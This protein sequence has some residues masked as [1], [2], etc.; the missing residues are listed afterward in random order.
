MKIR[1]AIAGLFCFFFAVCILCK[2]VSAGAILKNDPI[3]I[4]LEKSSID[5]Q[6]KFLNDLF[7]EI[8]IKRVAATK[9]TPDQNDLE[10]VERILKTAIQPSEIRKMY[11]DGIKSVMPLSE[12]NEVISWYDSP[13]GQ[14]I[15]KINFQSFNIDEFKKREEF[16]TDIMN[17]QASPRRLALIQRYMKSAETVKNSIK[18]EYEL[19]I[20]KVGQQARITSAPL[21]PMLDKLKKDFE[22]NHEQIEKKAAQKSF[23]NNLFSFRNHSD[24]D[25][26]GCADFIDTHAGHTFNSISH[27]VEFQVT[28]RFL[29]H[30]EEAML[31][32]S[33]EA[34]ETW[35][36]DEYNFSYTAPNAGWVK[37][38]ATNI[39]PNAKL[40]L[41]KANPQIF[42][43]IIPEII[44]LDNDLTLDKFVDLSKGNIKSLA[45]KCLISDGGDYTLNTIKGFQ[46]DV[47]AIVGNYSLSYRF[48]NILN[49]GLAYQL[50]AWTQDQNKAQM[51]SLSEQIFKGFQIID[52]DKTFYSSDYEPF[53]SFS[54]PFF[55][56]S[57]SL[58][59]QGWTKWNDLAKYNPEAEVGGEKN[60]SMFMVVPAHIGSEKVGSEVIL[61]AFLNTLDIVSSDKNITNLKE[62]RDAS[63]SGY[64]LNYH[65][66]IN[67]VPKN[68]AIRI[69]IDREIAYMIAAWTNEKNTDINVLANKLNQSFIIHNTHTSD[70][71]PGNMSES[72]KKAQASFDSFLGSFYY[73]A[74]QYEKALT[75][76][77][78][79]TD[80]N[81]SEEAYLTA[82]LSCYSALGSFEQGL[83]FLDKHHSYHPD[84]LTILSWKAW[85]LK[86][87][88]QNEKSLDIYR[89]LFEK[90]YRSDSDFIEFVD[91]LGTM[92]R[93]DD[94][95]PAFTAYVRKDSSIDVHI[96]QASLLHDQGKYREAVNLLQLLQKDMPFQADISFALARSFNAMEE[97]KDVITVA[98]ALITR[99]LYLTDAYFLKG[100]AEFDL[101][102]YHK[103]KESF[104]NALKE[105]PEDSQIKNYIQH[106]S[107]IIGQGDNTPIKNTIQPVPIPAE[108]AE[109]TISPSDTENY[110]NYGAYYISLIRGIHFE[111]GIGQR[112]TTY[113]KI[114]I[115]DKSGVT[116]FSTIEIE[117]DPLSENLY[118]NRLE[119]KDEKGKVVSTGD[120][121]DYYI[122][123]KRS[124]DMATHDKILNI[125]IPNLKP[126]YTIE[127]TCTQQNNSKDF[128]YHWDTLSASRPIQYSAIFVTGDTQLISNGT[129]NTPGMTL[130]KN[131]FAWVMTHPPI[132][133]WEPF[134]GKADEFLPVVRL[135]SSGKTW[136]TVGE[137]YLHDIAP[138]LI[139]DEKTKKLAVSLT[140]HATTTADK[141]RA[142][143][144]HIQSDFT[145]KA[146]EFGKRAIIP[147][148]SQ[149]TI[150]KKYGDCKDHAVLLH[151]MLKA[152]SIPSSLVLVSVNETVVDELP[153]IGQFNHM[154]NYVPD[155]DGGRYIDTT[156]K[157]LDMLSHIPMGLAN[158][159]ALI[160]SEG[161]SYLKTIPPCSKDAFELNVKTNVRV[162]ETNDLTIKEK[163][164]FKG[165][166]AALMRDYL[167]S[168]DKVS[169]TN[170]LQKL[171]S[172]KIPKNTAFTLT[173]ENMDSH[174]KDLSFN[175]TYDVKDQCERTENRLSFTLPDIWMPYYLEVQ[176]VLDRKTDFHL[177]YPM[178]LDKHVTLTIPEGFSLDSVHPSAGGGKDIFGA[179]QTRATKSLPSSTFD[180]FY[181]CPDG[182]FE[183]NTYPAFKVFSDKA[184]EGASPK[185]VLIKI[186]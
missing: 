75:W 185:I 161:N 157:H 49:N 36:F 181:S 50:V 177:S 128:A 139:L 33:S 94:I 18:L 153:T 109:Q 66:V 155:T 151:Q 129:S 132:Y 127:L 141:I 90:G 42:F 163:I 111:K 16:E 170:W 58:T 158:Q 138:K 165:Y 39:N 92:K 67:K 29:S 80:L 2:P 102:W 162:S 110:S 115:L 51:V 166:S 116:A 101:R 169:Y 31:G 105:S 6:I 82:S 56:Y 79:A 57:I 9:K 168:V 46:H 164:I 133:H 160:I 119:V 107:G 54:S 176:P 30:I 131:G 173:V 19:A 78:K 28:L 65:R 27:D 143:V 108:I 23:I 77:R 40:C 104:E 144:S 122:L 24:D 21:Q 47:D 93:W 113:R 87:L 37:I 69:I 59:G 60:D 45:S 34:S 73:K 145:Y 13:L 114:K 68:F 142:L 126:G 70:F 149:T 167:L 3:D 98:E 140:K 63:T 17:L 85:L 53:D 11:Y 4:L 26:E 32:K 156:S 12:I 137:E 178:V 175:I 121:S 172:D 81:T 136:Q 120:C 180:Y 1:G 118:V 152:V 182:R 41:I 38:D 183:K 124:S 74:K 72:L 135:A 171:Y 76:L 148:T 7:R 147:N 84:N 186:R 95:D 43:M 150:E 64:T 97:Y 55:N 184:I 52:K 112:L 96:K 22:L 44:G 15:V 179:W 88:N 89:P 146:I 159:K 103:A 61:S 5:G 106:I 71:N 100:E 99:K 123:D 35:S 83:E 62:F 20:L 91:L 134:Q 174:T 86:K 125:P 8:L 130:L 25:L 14:R 154:I 48:W 10:K 117:F